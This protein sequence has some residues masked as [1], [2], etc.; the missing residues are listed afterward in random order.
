MDAQ[1]R[2]GA[3]RYYLMS[4]GIEADRLVASGVALGADKAKGKGPRIEIVY[5]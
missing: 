2:L 1:D 5:Q 4:K 3:V